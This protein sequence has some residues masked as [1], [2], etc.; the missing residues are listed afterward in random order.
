MSTAAGTPIDPSNI[1]PDT[2]RPTPSTTMPPEH[3][4]TH[5]DDVRETALPPTG[6]AEISDVTATAT[7]QDVIA[8][9]V[10]ITDVIVCN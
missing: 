7:R 6:V 9:S 1:R 2:E 8:K 4:Y 10:Q 5:L 3:G